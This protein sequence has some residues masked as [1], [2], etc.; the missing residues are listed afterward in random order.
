MI[1]KS[2]TETLKDNEID[3][4]MNKILNKLKNNFQITQ[5]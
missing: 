3:E 4:I 2:D 5:R 1:F